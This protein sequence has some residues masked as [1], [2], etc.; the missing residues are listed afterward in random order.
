MIIQ[1]IPR[2]TPQTTAQ[3]IPLTMT[4][5]MIHPTMTPRMTAVTTIHP[6]T[7]IPMTPTN[8]HQPAHTTP[9]L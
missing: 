5:T 2:M 9:L 8:N 1:R 7:T 3:K 4:L 6:M